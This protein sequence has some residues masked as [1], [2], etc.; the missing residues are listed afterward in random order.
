MR[1]AEHYLYAYA[2]VQER[3]GTCFAWTF[4]VGG[5]YYY[6]SVIKPY[7]II[8]EGERHS[9]MSF[10]SLVA[11]MSGAADAKNVSDDGQGYNIY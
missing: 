3:R 8:F 7:K 1:D 2:F 9:P 10:D 6:Y 11:A 5:I 4:M